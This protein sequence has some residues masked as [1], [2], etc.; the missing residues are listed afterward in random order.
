MENYFLLLYLLVL[1]KYDCR[2]KQVPAVLVYAGIGCALL[3]Q[4]QRWCVEGV[5]IGQIGGIMP[6][7]FLVVMAVVTRK[8]GMADGL[9]LIIVGVVLGYPGSFYVFCISLLLF[10]GVSI[11]LL[12][13]R[14]IK[15][16]ETLPYLPFLTASVIIEHWI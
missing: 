2:E 15:V 5:S 7:F 3:L 9:V 16:R 13:L 8:A 10:S 14:K 11:V 4:I 12:L 1:S 6:G